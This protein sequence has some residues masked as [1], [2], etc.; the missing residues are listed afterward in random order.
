MADI[1][2][3]YLYTIKDKFS[4]VVKK[5]NRSLRK[6]KGLIKSMNADINKFS[7]SFAKV[8]LVGTAAFTGAT[9]AAARFESGINKVKTLMDKPIIRKFS[10]DLDNA[11]KGAIGLGFGMADATTSLFNA[12]S[13]IGDVPKS[14]E[15]F[16]RAQKLAIAGGAS[17]SVSVQGITAVIN[18]YKLEI[19]DTGIVAESFF[20]GQRFGTTDVAKL[21]ANIGKVA[22]V[23]KDAGV[24]FQLL[25]A[26]MAEL[27]QGGLSTEIASTGL[28]AALSALK[29]PVASLEPL[30]RKLQIPFGATELAA[31]DF[32]VVLR[33]IAI[34]ARDNKDELIKLIP[35]MEALNTF[36]A[37]N[38][39]SILNIIKSVELMNE[40]YK[41]GRG[42]VEAY[43]LVM[44]ETRQKALQTKGAFTNL[45]VTI[46]TDLLP[47]TNKILDATTKFLD[48]LRG[49]SPE[50]RKNAERVGELVVGFTA[51]LVAIAG[52]QKI[53]PLIIGSFGILD[54]VVGILLGP[55]GLLILGLGGLVAIAVVLEKKYGLV[56]KIF[57]KIVNALKDI[58]RIGITSLKKIVFA[59]TK[60]SET[61]KKRTFSDIDNT[62][63]TND[64]I[65]KTAKGQRGFFDANININAPKGTVKSIETK[66]RGIPFM[67]LGLNL[68]ET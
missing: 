27:T 16:N 41:T 22:P 64:L 3:S 66:K 59:P 25:I 50:A 42:L 55:V 67:P 20:T 6:Q 51:L 52:V 17:L 10:G 65:S 58:K 1:S 33:N 24:S 63:L 48:K 62:G 37:L 40:N 32:T 12:Q 44:G 23:A 28:R 34:A 57:E 36:A 15:V 7:G 30:Y 18:A 39:Q 21:A 9:V 5:M 19:E 35:N 46:G 68:Q 49:M 14:L 56:S 26:T 11:A 8:A 45:A 61:A 43:T 29:K 47:V 60:E 54:G 53:M 2:I 31:A 38:E 13:A 4:G